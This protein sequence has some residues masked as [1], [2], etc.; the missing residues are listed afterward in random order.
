MPLSSDFYDKARD[1]IARY[2]ESRSALIMLLHEAH[3]EAGSMSSEVI[4]EVA[5]LLGLT[6][7]DVAGV[8]TFYTMFKRSNPGR[9][10]ISLCTNISCAFNGAE[11]TAEALEGLVG[12]P[13][14]P[15]G[16][17]LCSW[18]PVE[19]LAYCSWAPVAQ[20]N[21]HDV[22]YMTPARAETLIEALRS[23][24]SLED[25]LEEFR[26]AQSLREALGA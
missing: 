25:V 3:D 21:Y 18:E 16:D 8:A 13:H 11:Q 26:G 20:V 14:T 2:P 12:P 22:P 9:F 7:A 24:R 10:L 17:G 19:C 23:G 1:I 6:P 15:T 5:K 4:R